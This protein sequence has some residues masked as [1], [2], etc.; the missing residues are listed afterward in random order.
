VLAIFILEH[1]SIDMSCVAPCAA[2]VDVILPKGTELTPELLQRIATYNSALGR[3][4]RQR[5]MKRREVMLQSAKVLGVAG[6][7]Q[8]GNASRLPD[9]SRIKSGNTSQELAKPRFSEFPRW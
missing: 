3:A 6:D 4:L 2:Q 1:S 5:S 9:L 8:L 7:E